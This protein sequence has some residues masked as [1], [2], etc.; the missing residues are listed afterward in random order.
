MSNDWNKTLIGICEERKEN[1]RAEG[2][3]LWLQKEGGTE[4]GNPV[5]QQVEALGGLL[6]ALWSILHVPV[7]SFELAGLLRNPRGAFAI[8]LCFLCHPQTVI[9]V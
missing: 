8:E 4:L 2:A 1:K 7:F 5:P 9:F 3:I 6:V